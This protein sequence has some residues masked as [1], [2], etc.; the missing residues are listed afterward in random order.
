MS[1]YVY[2]ATGATLISGPTLTNA[3]GRADFM[4]SGAASPGTQ[5]LVR[6]AKAAFGTPSPSYIYVIEP[7][8]V[9]DNDYN[10]IHVPNSLEP[11]SDPRLCR[12]TC[13]FATPDGKTNVFSEIHLA[14]Q[15]TPSLL[16]AQA[17][18]A[19]SASF[20]GNERVIV[21]PDSTGVA[22]VDLIRNALYL[23]TMQG[24][25]EYPEQVFIP[26][27]S[28]AD[29]TD[30]L[31]PYPKQVTWTS[32]AVALVAGASTTDVATSA[33]L[34]N[35]QEWIDDSPFAALEAVTS[36]A[37]VATVTH[38]GDKTV[39]ITAVAAGSCTISLR[40]A[41]EQEVWAERLPLPTLSGT[42]AVTVT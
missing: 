5:Y 4:L 37:A 26:D 38:D 18:A 24:Y 36:D 10:L 34:S 1:V 39:A 2:D 9:G 25:E 28:S 15:R 41:A 8:A 11:A 30:L 13:Y 33:L 17:G 19:H 42:I 12:C 31:M 40:L 22:K 32:A 23:V 7:P 14:L 16:T 35:T 20:L 29:L 27:Q 21:A 3:A 6:T